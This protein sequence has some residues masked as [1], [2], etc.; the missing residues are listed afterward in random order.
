MAHE[1]SHEHH[2][3]PVGLY[4]GIYALLLV[5]L[6]LTV[7]VARWDMGGIINNGVALAIAVVKALLVILF[8]MGTRYSSKLTWLW[9]S[10][11]FAFLIIMLMTVGD[12][13]TRNWESVHG[14]AVH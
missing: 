14:W 6:V 9:A 11:G 5:L 1:Q 13:I 10:A 7:L 12:Y 2:V 3:Q 4:L 8:F